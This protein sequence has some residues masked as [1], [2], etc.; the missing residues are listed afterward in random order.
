MS[1]TAGN[2]NGSTL[3]QT[4]YQAIRRR[5][6]QAELEP[7]AP[8][9]E[10]QLAAAL[11][12]SRTP[13][14]ESLQML[15]REGLVRV[16]PQRGAYVAELSTQ[17]IF[18]IYQIRE[19][20]ESL[21]ARIAA[22]RL[23]EGDLAELHHLVERMGQPGNPLDGEA[24]TDADMRLHRLIVSTTKNRRLEQI[25]GTLDDQ[26]HRL[27]CLT[28]RYLSQPNGGRPSDSVA[29]HAA[30][31]QALRSRNPAEAERAMRRHLQRARDSVVRLTLPI[32]SP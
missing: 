5:I 1:V 3:R 30:I 15:E 8:L 2:S 18:E 31:V 17:D 7:G 13:I 21:A 11:G 26:V 6:I 25:L 32:A 22:E 27:R 12:I 10:N 9:S 24:V 14:R 23:T 19:Q 20:L 28:M 29:E 16:I 4:A